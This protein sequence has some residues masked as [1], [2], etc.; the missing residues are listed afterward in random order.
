MPN[1]RKLRAMRVKSQRERWFI[2]IIRSLEDKKEWWNQLFRCNRTFLVVHNSYVQKKCKKK[3]A[4][5]VWIVQKCLIKRKRT[6]LHASAPWQSSTLIEFNRTLSVMFCFSGKRDDSARLAVSEIAPPLFI[7]S[8][9][10]GHIQA[11]YW[12]TE[13]RERILDNTAAGGSRCSL[14]SCSFNLKTCSLTLVELVGVWPHQS[15]SFKERGRR[16]FVAA[17]AG[18]FCKNAEG[19]LAGHAYHIIHFAQLT[20]PF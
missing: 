13:H 11:S 4:N 17:K 5:G 10:R 18:S 7:H 19:F 1:A 6:P 8:K 2:W 15:A 3:A 12:K 20:A 16:G 9:G 14:K